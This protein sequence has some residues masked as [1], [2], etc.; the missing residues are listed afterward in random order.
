[1]IYSCQ[2]TINGVKHYEIYNSSGKKIIDHDVD[3]AYSNTWSW[4]F[5]KHSKSKLFKVYDYYGKDLGMDSIESSQSVY[6]RLNR[7]G[8]QR[9]GKWGF[10][11]KQGKLRIPHQYDEISHFKNNIAAVKKGNEIFMIDTNG[12]RSAVVYNPSDD[13][14]S[15]ED[16]DIAIGMGADFFHSQFKKINEN[17][18]VGLL[19][20]SSNQVI[21]PVE[22]DRLMDLKAPFKLI[23]AGK[24]GKYGVLTFGGGV[25]IPVEYESVFVLNDYF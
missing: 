19:D 21:I 25:V 11:D 17:G 8:L 4:L 20:V 24:N 15:F 23:S 16:G 3:W 22:Y 10:Y 12:A 6:L 7:A 2:K 9:N 1:M 5:V 14:Y 13:D 18:K